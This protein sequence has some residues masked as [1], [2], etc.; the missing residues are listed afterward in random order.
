MKLSRSKKK[1]LQK[2]IIK[3]IIFI[4]F[5]LLIYISTVFDCCFFRNTIYNYIYKKFKNENF[6]RENN[7][8]CDK[9]DPIF[10][11]AE[12][13][14]KNPISLCKSKK[15][16]HIC[17]QTSKYNKYNKIHEIKYG[18]ICKSEN[19]ILDPSKSTQADFIF[20][21]TFDKVHRGEP[22][23]SKGFFNM[24]CDINQ[25]IRKYHKFYETYFNSWKYENEKEKNEENEQLPE[26]APG[27][28]IFFISRN[29]DSPNLFHGISEFLNALSIIY[30]FDLNPE[31]IQIVFLESMIFQNDPLYILFKNII[32]RG[33]EP[34]LLRNLKQRY[35]IFTAFH[36]P[37]NYDSPLFVKLNNKKGFPDCK[38]STQAYNILNNF[39]NKYFNISIFKDSFIA[40]R[41][42]F[43]YPES[44]IKN[45]KLNNTFNKT[46]TIQWRKVWPKGRI[47]QERILGNGPELADKLSTILPKNYLIRLVDTASL[48]IEE[49]ISIMRKTDYF[50]GVHGAGLSLSIF[51]PYQSIVYEILPKENIKVLLL[52]SALSGH[53]VYSD[54]IKSDLKIINNNQVYF[55]DSNL[56]IKKVIKYI[57][58]N[59]S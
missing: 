18:V 43:Y 34:I 26:L 7:I 50:I 29:H 24:K 45:S 44:I 10:I 3:S 4:F 37:I 22:I 36:I 39:I 49:Q 20:K 23:L 1:F 9:Y 40:D 42:I 12:R 31:N 19:F 14:K 59:D 15:S 58:Q 47:N 56:F 16:N 41:D 21:G 55:F 6:L 54:I 57:K 5:I 25:N 33:G 38:Y 28:T 32:S 53:K 46:I 8:N 48:S 35:H 52:M 51:M 11:M 17:Y 13:F 2:R 27:K 30:L